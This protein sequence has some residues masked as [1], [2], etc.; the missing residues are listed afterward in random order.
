MIVNR[1]FVELYIQ[2]RQALGTHVRIGGQDAKD[3]PYTIVGIVDNVKHNGLTR[4]VKAQFYAPQP[5]FATSPGNTSRNMTLVVRGTGKPEQLIAPVRGIIKQLDPRLP[6]SDVRSMNEVVQ[7]AIAAPRF[8][9]QLL[10]LFGVLALL[11]SAIGIFGIVSQVVASRTQEFGIRAALGAT[12]RNLLMLSLGSGVRQAGAGL[13]VGVAVALALT[14]TMTTMLQ[15]VTPTDPLTF[16][17]VVGVTAVVAIG[18]SLIPARRAAKTDL[19]KVM[20]G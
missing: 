6:I 1:R 17:S 4:E 12:P 14:R 2:G 9:M 16:A 10:G 8:A 5:Q 3:P 20:T 7:Q 15:G 13:V 11:L 18:A 19:A